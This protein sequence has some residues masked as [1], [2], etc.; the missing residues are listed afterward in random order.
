MGNASRTDTCLPTSEVKW[1]LVLL[2]VQLEKKPAFLHYQLLFF[3]TEQT[4]ITHIK[5]IRQNT[6]SKQT[7]RSLFDNQENELFPKKKALHK[8]E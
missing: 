8:S 7:S 2:L 1:C 5:P 6:T 4:P 3:H